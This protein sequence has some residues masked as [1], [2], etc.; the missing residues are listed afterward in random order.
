MVEQVLS[1]G[2]LDS[3]FLLKALRSYLQ[4][5]ELGWIWRPQSYLLKRYDWSTGVRRYDCTLL[6]PR[7]PL[8]TFEKKVRPEPENGCMIQAYHSLSTSCMVTWMAWSKT[9]FSDQSADQTGELTPPSHDDLPNGHCQ[10]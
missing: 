7:P 10:G 2:P 5:V 9:D 1:R 8:N 4:K 3:K 6:A